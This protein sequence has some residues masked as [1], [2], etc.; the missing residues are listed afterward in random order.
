MGPYTNKIDGFT[1]PTVLLASVLMLAV[2]ATA[3]QLVSATSASLRDQ[4]YNR[5]AREAAEAGSI[6]ASNCI[7]D[8]GAAEPTWTD[9][10][11]LKPNTDCNGNAVSGQS[12]Y[13]LGDT[14]AEL[15]STFSVGVD[16]ALMPIKGI[17]ERYRESE[18]TPWQVISETL[19]SQGGGEMLYATEIS[20][21]L[22]QVCAIMSEEVWC[23]GG[24]NHGQMGNGRV[25]PLPPA[26]GSALYLAPQKIIRQTGVLA[27][28]KDKI[29]LSGHGRACVVTTDNQIF[30]WGLRSY[31]SLG[32]GST[33]G[34]YQ[35][36]PI[37]V[38][39]PANMTGPVTGITSSYHSMCAISSGDVWCWGRN[40]KGQIGDGTSTQRNV[41]VR[42][43]TIGTTAGKPV[44]DIVSA[45]YSSSFCAVAAGDVYCW[46]EN[47]Y[48]Q[49]GDGTTTQRNVPTPVLK[50][51]GKL[52]GKTVSKVVYAYAPRVFDG[53]VDTADGTGG[54]CTTSNRDC[55]RGSHSCALTTDGQMFCWGSNTYGQMGQGSWSITPQLTPIKVAGAL[56]GKVVRDIATAYQTPCALTTEASSG[57][58]FYCWG[59]NRQGAGG[60]GH[61]KMCDSSANVSLCSPSPVVMQTPGLANKDIDS[62]SGGV[63]RI[64]A[65][66]DGVSYCAGLN[67]S[68]QIGDG[69]TTTRTVP[70]EAKLLRQYRPALVF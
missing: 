54:T 7:E 22:W 57:N 38:A 64:C 29:V 70:T 12:P 34:G 42:L 18:T 47:T 60:F 35:T 26:E 67:S 30:C 8:S 11:P 2:L 14:S 45:P 46:G 48:G 58:R 10:K 50:Q 16:G 40:D 55:Y 56:N 66:T 36:L 41:P 59:G 24:N 62:I 6:M 51:S 44:T 63:N 37:Q 49:L 43:S 31:G 4:Y 20:S 28:R 65:L 19:K 17:V 15:R 52:A 61:T 69:T 23:N 32:T 1:L 9:A 25:E 68:G 53:A 39:K 21:G 5:L 3:L 13:V 27:G 33:E